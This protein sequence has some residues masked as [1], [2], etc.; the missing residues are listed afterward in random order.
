MD[1]D[2]LG[3]KLVEQLVDKN[4]IKDV[5]DLYDLSKETLS[6]L[7]RMADK[8]ADNIINAINASKKRPFARFIYALGIRHVG[9]HISALLA[10]QYKD[11]DELA[12][13][14]EEELVNI[15]EIGP[16]VS[17]S[18]TTFFKDYKNNKTIERILSSGVEIEYKKEEFKPL[19]GLT[20]VFTGTMKNISREEAR[21]KVEALGAKTS[22]SVSKKVD[23]LVAGVEAGSKLDKAGKLGIKV[24]NEEEFVEMTRA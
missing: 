9:E 15:P 14:K 18:I 7:D 22:S 16:E 2:G 6:G 8:S 3:E 10:E 13:A 19:K 24:L 1:I 20:F 12:A 4:I 21:K 11:M 17:N 5:S 23:Y